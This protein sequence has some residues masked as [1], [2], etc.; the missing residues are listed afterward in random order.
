MTD[1]KTVELPVHIT[2]A[3]Q[4]AWIYKELGV[5]NLDEDFDI[6]PNVTWLR[7]GVLVANFLGTRV[8]KYDA[9]ALV[10]MGSRMLSAD[11]I[12]VSMDTHISSELINPK[13]GKPWV[14]GEMQNLCNDEGA[15][16]T[17]L[18]TDAI[19]TFRLGKD[20]PSAMLS[21]KYHVNHATREVHWVDPWDAVLE[22][23]GDTKLTGFVLDSMK[24]AWDSDQPSFPLLPP[25]PGMTEQEAQVHRNC[26]G[27][28]FMTLLVGGGGI[29][30]MEGMEDPN[31][32]SIYEESLT[33]E[34]VT[35][36]AKVFGSVMPL[37]RGRFNLD[38]E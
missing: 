1:S 10:V 21:R 19:S 31:L 33:L 22:D 32:A 35:E 17:G 18:I 36:D 8:N 37:L 23:D 29:F 25:A 30:P 20:V 5:S 13:T 4:Q 15:C 28:R 2:D 7:D 16:D 3:A 6:A 34:R 38:A 27:L 11:E 26:V 24:A 9:I 12:V 14:P